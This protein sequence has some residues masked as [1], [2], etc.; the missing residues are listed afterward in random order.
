MKLYMK[1]GVMTYRDAYKVFDENKE[2]IYKIKKTAFSFITTFKM[3]NYKT[4]EIECYIKRKRLSFM[5]TYFLLDKNKNKIATVKK[6]FTI[7]PSK[8]TLSG[9]DFVYNV[10][11]NINAYNFEI[12]KNEELMATIHKK[13]FSIGDSYEI[14]IPKEDEAALYSSMTLAIDVC[15][16]NYRIRG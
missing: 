5:P 10:E 15:L 9:N 12:Y 1:Q 16:H 14:D 2:L 8:F 3:I 13:H 4:K 6:H 11:G 7:G